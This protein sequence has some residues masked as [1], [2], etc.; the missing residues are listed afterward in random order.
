M[1]KHKP[2]VDE[3]IRSFGQGIGRD[4]VLLYGEVRIL[5]RGDGGQMAR[6]DVGDKHLSCGADPLGEPCRYRAAT[7]PN[8]Q[9]TP[10]LTDATRLQIPDGRGIVRAL[11]LLNR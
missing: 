5:W 10:A 6:I 2:R 3:I 4:I 9:A 11:K 7:A 1:H 8:L